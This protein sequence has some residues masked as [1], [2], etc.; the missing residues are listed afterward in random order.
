MSKKLYVGN[1]P[2]SATED[3]IRSAFEAYGEVISINLIEDRETGR[4]RGFGFVEM[5]DSGALEVIANMDGKDFGGRNLK[6]NEAK[7]RE[8]RPRW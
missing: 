1:L 4:P 3:E 2:W 8:E 5:D 7:P 6:V